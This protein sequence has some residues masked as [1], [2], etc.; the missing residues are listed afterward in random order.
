MLLARGVS[1]G[2]SG[3]GYAQARE[4]ALRALALDDGCADAQM[5]LGA[6]AFLGDWDWIGAERS[7]ARALEINPNHTEAYV[8]Y[9]RLL[10][11]LGRLDEGLAMKM[12]ALERD[13]SSPLVHQAISLSVLESAPFRRHGRVGDK[14][15]ELDPR[16]LV[17]REHLAGRYW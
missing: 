10:D 16:H 6:I 2:A 13:P 9:G 15:L 11:A 3:R 5:A 1:P 7:L 4:A 17:A 14:T 8:L 12:R